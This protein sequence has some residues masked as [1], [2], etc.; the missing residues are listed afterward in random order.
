[1]NITFGLTEE[2]FNTQYAPL[3]LLLALYQQKQVLRPLENVVS[4]AKIVNF[5]VADKLQQIL[6]SILANCETISEVN[7]KL[8]GD[9]PLAQTGGWERFADQSTLSLCLDALTLMN[10]EQLRAVNRQALHNYGA[11]SHHDWRKFL[12]LDFDLS[13][14]PCGSQAEASTK[15]YFGEKKRHW[16]TVSPCHGRRSSGNNLV[17]AVSGQSTYSQLST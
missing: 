13:G 9:R 4:Q 15:G 12:W 3:G 14:L 16:P 6:V 1:M 2:M 8:K 17:K 10:I 5:S 11:T 7:T